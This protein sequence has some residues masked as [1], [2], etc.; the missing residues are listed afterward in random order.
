MTK[1]PSIF[2]EGWRMPEFDRPAEDTRER[3]YRSRVE[4][5]D[6]CD[7]AACQTEKK[8]SCQKPKKQDWLDQQEEAEDFRMNLLYS[9]EFPLFSDKF[10][11]VDHKDDSYKYSRGKFEDGWVAHCRSIQLGVTDAL[12][13]QGSDS[14]KLTA[15]KWNQDAKQWETTSIQNRSKQDSKK[16]QLTAGRWNND[17][18]QWE[19]ERQVEKDS[20]SGLSAGKWDRSK[21]QW[22]T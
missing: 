19:T 4:V 17:S 5:Q 11:N 2:D 1:E 18:Q 7:C 22:I 9:P 13:S 12:S 3:T 15:G 8:E 10:Y 14:R 20:V 21:K 6:E 16:P